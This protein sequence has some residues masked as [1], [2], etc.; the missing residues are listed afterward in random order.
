MKGAKMKRSETGLEDASNGVQ[1]TVNI[2]SATPSSKIPDGGWG[3]VIV[4]ISFMLQ[5]IG[6]Y[7]HNGVPESLIVCM[8]LICV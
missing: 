6:W 5:F 1:S 7:F 2:E 3:W 8:I 4:A